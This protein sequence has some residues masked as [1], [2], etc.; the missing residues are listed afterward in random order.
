MEPLQRVLDRMGLAPAAKLPVTSVSASETRLPRSFGGQVP[1]I[2]PS[3][4]ELSGG[5]SAQR[6]LETRADPGPS[7]TAAVGEGP[8]VA[9]CLSP[10]TLSRPFVCL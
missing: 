10:Q 3:A 8:C 5:C 9:A 7:E 4:P 2:H 1:G 6:P